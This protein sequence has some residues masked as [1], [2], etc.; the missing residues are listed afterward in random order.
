[1]SNPIVKRLDDF[2][3]RPYSM[4][5]IAQVTAV[6]AGPPVTVDLD[7][8]G[9]TLTGNPVLGSYFDPTV[10][11]WVECQLRDSTDLV[12]IGAYRQSAGPTGPSG[13]P[14]PTGP[15][16]PAGAT[17][18]TGPAGQGFTYRGVWAAGTAYNAY[19]VVTN[20][21]STY[22]TTVHQDAASTFLASNWNLWAAKGADGAAGGGATTGG[23][24]D[25]TVLAA[26]PVLYLKFDEASGATTAAD[27]SP[28][29]ATAT[30]QLGS[31]SQVAA[32]SHDAGT[33]A[34]GFNGSK[35]LD[36]P[37]YAA[38]RVT[39]FTLEALVQIPSYATADYAVIGKYGT[40]TIGGWMLT[41]N[42]G[43]VKVFTVGNGPYQGFTGTTQMSLNNPHHI[44]GVC[45]GTNLKVY[46]DGVLDG[47]TA[48]TVQ[49]TQS[50]NPARVGSFPDTV[51]DQF[52]GVLDGVA[53]YGTALSAAQV[54]AHYQASLAPS[55]GGGTTPPAGQVTQTQDTPAL[56]WTVN[57][58][59]NCRPEVSVV[60]SAG[61]L[62]EGAVKYLTLN[63]LTISFVVA[64]SGTVT[65]TY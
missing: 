63:S 29:S 2:G 47:S 4:H 54:L 57:H 5:R 31:A 44:V 28:N 30:Y 52:N 20:A 12:V 16:G 36:L 23:N 65:L 19:D 35:Y 50:T 15:T 11:D 46:L 8:D 13:P 17:G 49:P 43:R 6:H 1:M 45:D 25:A 59:L 53:V 10:G 33:F 41:V 48:I 61:T 18:P 34:A 14:G 22:V 38:L 27:A 7:L 60:D 42:N 9:A 40:G 24:Y 37:D 56:V 58:N 51:A 3:D 64:T 32:L 21:G 55:S 62:I 39:T 26:N